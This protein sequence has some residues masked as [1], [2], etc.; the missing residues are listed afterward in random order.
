MRWNRLP[1]VAMAAAMVAL[2]LTGCTGMG[3]A[4]RGSAHTAGSPEEFAGL[5]LSPARIEPWED[6]ARTSGG[7]STSRSMTAPRSSSSS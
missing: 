1:V 6:G 5:G 7:T 3:P 4:V 2:I